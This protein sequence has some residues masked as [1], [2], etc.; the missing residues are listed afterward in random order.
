[1]TG[2]NMVDPLDAQELR[3]ALSGCVIGREIAILSTATSTNDEI[4]R[5]ATASAGEGLVIFA[6]E[7]TAGRGQHGNHWESAHKKGLWFSILLRPRIQIADSAR[8]THWATR[9]VATALEQEFSLLA[10]VKPPN[11]VFVSGKKIAGVLV[12]MRAQPKSEHIAIAGIGVNLN[13]SSEEFSEELRDRATS[14]AIL[15]GRNVDRTAVAI[16]L[17]KMLDT[18]Y[19]ETFAAD[20]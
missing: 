14:V 1:M 15:I 5:R 8:L 12:E 17:L 4:L 6:E 2:A 20:R 18:T 9:G 19:R 11:D 16:A 10:S 13:Q 3:R 7:Q